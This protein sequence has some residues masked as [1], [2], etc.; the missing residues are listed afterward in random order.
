MGG[1][2]KMRGLGQ[3]IC[4]CGANFDHFSVLPLKVVGRL[5]AQCALWSARPVCSSLVN[6]VAF[7]RSAVVCGV[8]FS[9]HYPPQHEDLRK[10]F[11]QQYQQFSTDQMMQNERG[12]SPP[13]YISRGVPPTKGSLQLSF[14]CQRFRLF[15][16]GSLES[17]S[18]CGLVILISGLV[19][20]LNS[21]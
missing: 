1:G 15:S 8:L 14:Y 3:E 20:P 17:Y 9:N 2:K 4:C 7:F 5:D 12:V 10:G 11:I 16:T 19:F 13:S 18:G 6:F 21:Q